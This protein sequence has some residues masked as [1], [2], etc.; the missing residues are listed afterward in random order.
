M[1][2]FILVLEKEKEI[3][4]C[5]MVKKSFGKQIFKKKNFIVWC[6]A[7]IVGCFGY[8]IPVINIVS[9]FCDYKW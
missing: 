9:S 2:S 4:K 6:I 5:Q 1:D 7:S 8:L 3:S